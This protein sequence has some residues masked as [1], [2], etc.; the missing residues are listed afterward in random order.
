MQYTAEGPSVAAFWPTQHQAGRRRRCC[1]IAIAG[2]V[3]HY[4]VAILA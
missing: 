1:S 3:L 2:G 4:G